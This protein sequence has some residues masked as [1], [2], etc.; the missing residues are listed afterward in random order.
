MILPLKNE[1][2]T[3]VAEFDRMRD[4]LDIFYSREKDIF[5]KRLTFEIVKCPWPV[6]KVWLRDRD[7]DDIYELTKSQYDTL[8]VGRHSLKLDELKRERQRS[9]TVCSYGVRV[10]MAILR[11]PR[12]L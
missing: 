11:A 7:T 10:I 3:F 9:D 5:A 1:K 12:T 8:G 4:R 2:D 6:K